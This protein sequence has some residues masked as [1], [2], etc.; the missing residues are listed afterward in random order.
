MKR[1]TA[2]ACLSLH[3]LFLIFAS[4]A[5]ADSKGTAGESMEAIEKDLVTILQE[6]EGIQSELDRLEEI[7]VFPKAT[8][9]RIEIHRGGS[10]SAP[11]HMRILVQGKVEDDRDFS[12]AERDAFSGNTSHPLVFHLPGNHQCRFE[13]LHPSWNVAPS[14]EFL[15]TIRKGETFLVRF[16]LS[17]PEGKGNPVLLRFKEK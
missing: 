15:A 6:M 2:A 10:V 16:R 4:P 14:A 13:V 5:A 3:L 1:V 9:I 12:K 8:G 7:A 11:V 17:S